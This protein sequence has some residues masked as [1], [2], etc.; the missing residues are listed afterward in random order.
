MPISS[1]GKWLFF[2]SV[3]TESDI[4]VADLVPSN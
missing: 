4:Y 1:D 2:S 3:A